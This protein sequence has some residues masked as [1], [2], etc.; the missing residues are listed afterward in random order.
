VR[1]VLDSIGD[2]CPECPPAIDQAGSSMLDADKSRPR[3][4]QA[5]P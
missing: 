5:T 2:A 3:R 4:V 1:G